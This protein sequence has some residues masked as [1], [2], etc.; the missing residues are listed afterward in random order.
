M[1]TVSLVVKDGQGR[2]Q[3]IGT[4]PVEVFPF[5]SGSVRGTSLVSPATFPTT[6]E[7]ML[8]TGERRPLRVQLD[9]AFPSGVPPDTG[10]SRATPRW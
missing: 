7:S 4:A 1:S 10:S 5:S 3:T 6:S 8:G 2:S 9:L